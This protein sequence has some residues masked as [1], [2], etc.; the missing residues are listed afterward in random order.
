MGITLGGFG[1]ALLLLTDN[2]NSLK[3]VKK[4]QNKEDE[5]NIINF[6][7]EKDSNLIEDIKDDEEI[8]DYLR[9]SS[10]NKPM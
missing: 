7:R 5:D 4:N 10:F 6:Y 1:G 3:N 9:D 8:I 2:S